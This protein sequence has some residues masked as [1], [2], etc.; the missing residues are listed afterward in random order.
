MMDAPGSFYV[1][2]KDRRVLVLS[3]ASN[4][5]RDVSVRISNITR[6]VL[7][8]SESV[9]ATLSDNSSSA[10][11]GDSSNGEVTSVAAEEGYMGKYL[12]DLRKRISSLKEYREGNV[13]LLHPFIH[14]STTCQSLYVI[15]V[16]TIQR[17]VADKI[18]LI[19]DPARLRRDYHQSHDSSDH[20][21][22]GVGF[23]SLLTNL[24]L[25]LLARY[26]IVKK[27]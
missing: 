5:M 1:D 12:L 2:I 27:Q 9:M 11:G 25:Y 17:S 19:S 20:S 21:T 22:S 13:G 16:G 15:I 6:S 7:G 24:S 8:W 26:V 23:W 14:P 3:T 10:L 4:N 18:E